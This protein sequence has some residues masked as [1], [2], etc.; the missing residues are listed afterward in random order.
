MIIVISP[1]KTLDFSKQDYT[2]SKSEITFAKQSES[3]I[4]ILKQYT[5]SEIKDM[6][7]I[8]DKLALLNFDRF[9]EWKFPF[10]SEK[11]KQALLAFKGDVYE[12]IDAAS[13][14]AEDFEEAQNKLRILSG[15]YGILKPMDLILPYRLE[16]G[17]KLDNEKGSNLYAYWDDLLTEHLNK[18]LQKNGNILINLASNEYFKSLK[19]KNIDAE[20]ITPVFK[21]F[22]NGNYKMISFYAKKA[23]GMMT[24]YIIQNKLT[25]PEDLKNFDMEGYSYNDRLT[26]KPNELVFTRG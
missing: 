14:S 6:M 25:D 18:D 3:L 20:I 21:D 17:T 10:N 22:K 15:L 13:F 7:K 24:R 11:T 23:R 19:K 4:S 26:T 16:M 12:G 8:S 2:D 1:A 5:V 9:Q